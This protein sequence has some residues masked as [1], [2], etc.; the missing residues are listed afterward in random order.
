MK[1]VCTRV[2]YSSGVTN[3][4]AYHL[5]ISTLHHASFI[6]GGLLNSMLKLQWTPLSN[7][8]VT[9]SLFFHSKPL[10][11]KQVL[12]HTCVTYQFTI[13]P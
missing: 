6:N 7:F 5:E 10:M 4:L 1:S 2:G 3:L 8:D 9:V 11:I 12:S 13:G